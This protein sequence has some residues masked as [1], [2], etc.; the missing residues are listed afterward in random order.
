MITNLFKK[1]LDRKPFQKRLE[2]KQRENDTISV[3]NRP[4]GCDPKVV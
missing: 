2:R 4:N 1:M 3:I